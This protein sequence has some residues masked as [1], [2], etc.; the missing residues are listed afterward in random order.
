M[1]TG[2]TAK[3]HTVISVGD[4]RDE[5]QPARCVEEEAVL[6]VRGISH[7]DTDTAP[8]PKTAVT[9]P[10]GPMASADRG[11]ALDTAATPR[12]LAQPQSQ[13]GRGGQTHRPAGW[14]RRRPRPRLSHKGPMPF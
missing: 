4:P 6:S 7:L 14:K 8:V 12:R 11:R 2:N 5:K 1:E 10:A 13:G 9:Q 3:A